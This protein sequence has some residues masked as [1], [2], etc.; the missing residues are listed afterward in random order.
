MS[1]CANFYRAH[2][3]VNEYRREGI[4]TT[5]VLKKFAVQLLQNTKAM[6]DD[7]NNK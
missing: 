4:F 2:L 1:V 5:H 3:Y 7:V 6:T